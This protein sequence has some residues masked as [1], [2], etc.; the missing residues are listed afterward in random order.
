MIND[1]PAWCIFLR[2]LPNGGVERQFSS[3]A[4]LLSTKRQVHFVSLFDGDAQGH[5][6]LDS[7]IPY[8]S[9]YSF[10]P[11]SKTPLKA[12]LGGP[13]RLRKFCQDNNI[14]VIYSAREVANWVAAR[15]AGNL[16]H[17]RLLWGHRVSKHQFSIRIRIMLELCK[18]VQHRVTTQIANSR[19]GLTAYQ[20]LGLCQGKACYIPNFLNTQNFAPNN[21]LR[22]WQRKEWGINSAEFL[23]GISGRIAPMKGHSDFLSIASR[24]ASK[25]NH[26][27]FIIIGS[28][29]KEDEH[30]LIV[31]IKDLRLEDQIVRIPEIPMNLMSAAYNGL[32]LLCSTSKFGEG[33]SNTLAEAMACGLAVVSTDVGEAR[34]IVKDDSNL[35]EAGDIR[36]LEQAII[37]NIATPLPKESSSSLRQYIMNVCN[38]EKILDEVISIGEGNF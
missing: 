24:I 36:G 11:G 19:D 6:L 2:S 23:I 26:V 18:R 13:G 21:D 28:G 1:H 20:D 22:N 25:F 27:K 30:E 35:V 32:D 7:T 5:G 33:F 8:T 14:G 4:N 9:L 37:K 12:L 16:P 15:A 17:V 34:A 10:D 3:L 38:N 29:T 31:Q